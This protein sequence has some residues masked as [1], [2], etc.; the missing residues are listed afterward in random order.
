MKL[1][2]PS[3]IFHC[4]TGCLL[5][6]I[7]NIALANDDAPNFPIPGACVG[8]ASG[9]GLENPTDILPPQ[10]TAYSVDDFFDPPLITFYDVAGVHPTSS[11]SNTWMAIIETPNE[12]DFFIDVGY[13]PILN[14]FAKTEAKGI[15]LNAYSLPG[16]YFK[17]IGSL[18]FPIIEIQVLQSNGTTAIANATVQFHSGV[19]L[20]TDD[21]TASLITVV[22]DGSGIVAL[23]CFLFLDG[24]N[25][26]TVYNSDLD[27]LFDAPVTRTQMAPAKFAIIAPGSGDQQ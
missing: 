13:T 11:T 10:V 6:F 2:P 8:K 19:L 7:S 12:E 1:I 27:Y 16:T 4:L 3:K 18:I 26:V 23:E 9:A 22:A 21:A 24:T 20:E 17:P 5:A 15:G 25:W 14:F